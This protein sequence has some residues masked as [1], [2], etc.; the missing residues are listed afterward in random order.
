[1]A[2]SQYDTALV[3][4]ASSGIGAAVTRALCAL[5]LKVYALAR[6]QQALAELADEVGCIPIVAD[7]NDT[8]QLS[9]ALGDLPIDILVNNAGLGRGFKGLAKSTGDD[10]SRVIETNVS[11]VLQVTRLVM[12]GM[13]ERGRGHIVNLGS[14]AGIHPT[15]LALYGASKGAIH[16]FCQNLRLELRGSGVRVTEICPGRVETPFFET[17]L[18]D[19]NDASA[20]TQGFACLTP[21]DI[22][23]SILYAVQVPWRCNITT[24][25]LQPTEQSV[26]GAHIDPV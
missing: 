3:T 19:P 5:G 18:D 17:A 23:D 26:G 22:A 20:F 16:L 2:D 4:G 21:Q 12:P 11:A 10:I 15:G 8:E 1:M 25:E 14:I 13:V 7:V 9:A 24:I 6:R